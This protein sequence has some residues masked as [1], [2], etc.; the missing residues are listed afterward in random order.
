MHMLSTGFY[1]GKVLQGKDVDE[2]PSFAEQI[3]GG[4]RP[5]IPCCAVG[6]LAVVSE[7]VAGKQNERLGSCR[8]S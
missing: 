5:L 3:C 7:N 1:K 8:L 6:P 4:F 2:K